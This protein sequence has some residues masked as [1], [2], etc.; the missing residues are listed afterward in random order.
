[1]IAV[2]TGGNGFVGRA[3]VE[4]LLVAGDEVRVIGRAR[5]PELERLGVRSFTS[6]LAAQQDLGAVL[7]GAEVVFHVAA[8]TGVWG[9]SQDFHA[10]NVTAT[11]HVVREAIRAGVPKLVYTSSPS[12]VIGDKDIANG[13]ESLP[14]PA[15]FLAPYPLT[16]S[17]AERFVLAQHEILACALRPHLIWGPRDPHIMPRLIDRAKRGRLVRVGEGRNK[18][19]I[20]YVEN[21]A[22]GHIQAAAA[23]RA[24]G[25]VP[26]RAYFIGQAE[27]VVLW[28]FIGELLRQLELEPVRRSLPLPLALTLATVLECFNKQFRPH[29]EPVLTR[30]TASQLARSHWFSHA[31]ANRDFGYCAPVST[32]EGLV[33][34]VQILRETMFQ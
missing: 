2:V 33:R 16:K 11:Q 15:H 18:V 8:K 6:D 23:L 25:A 19:D 9:K 14:Y 20:S 29:E 27:P 28:D 31:A 4:R 24:G 17:I 22:I 1:M 21:V 34:T 12:V 5:Y 3:I 32:A 26:G 10:A 13:D 7:R 30:F